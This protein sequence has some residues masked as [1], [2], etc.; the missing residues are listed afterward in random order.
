M[1]P[2]HLLLL[3]TLLFLYLHGLGQ[4]RNPRA[5]N[6]LQ[7][8][9]N[10]CKAHLLCRHQKRGSNLERGILLLPPSVRLSLSLSLSAPNINPKRVCCRSRCRTWSPLSPIREDFLLNWTPPP[11]L[12]IYAIAL[13]REREREKA[14]P[15]T[16]RPGYHCLYELH[17]QCCCSPG[18]Y[19]RRDL[20][21]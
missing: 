10:Y 7:R 5:E 11:M 20:D 14:L 1:D 6:E 18:Q 9:T 21:S 2:L 3:R 17:T 4:S 15:L 8:P 16:F 19:T 13:K 12:A